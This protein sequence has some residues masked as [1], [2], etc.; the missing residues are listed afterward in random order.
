MDEYRKYCGT[1]NTIG[2]PFQIVTPAEVA[3]LWPLCNTD[4]LVGALY[5]PDDGHI[6]PADVTQAM[7]IG[8]RDMGAPRSTAT[9]LSPRWNG[10]AGRR[11]AGQ[12]DAGRHPL[13]ARG[14]R[15]RELQLAH[16]ADARDLHPGDPGG[17]PVHRHRRSARARRAAPAGPAGDGG[18][19]RIGRVLLPAGKSGRATSWDPT[20]KARRPGSGTAFPTVSS[21]TCSRATWTG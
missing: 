8:A 18:A 17:T 15:D 9:P 21:A 13:R 4:G 3:E 5:H 6:A 12:D 7:A 10:K 2:V 1:A 11:M 14:L 19:A 20:R 16:L